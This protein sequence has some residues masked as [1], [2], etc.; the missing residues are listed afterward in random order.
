MNKPSKLSLMVKLLFDANILYRLVKKLIKD[1]PACVHVSKTELSI[2]ALDDEIWNWAKNNDFVIVTND[3][4]FNNLSQLYGFPPKIIILRT[5]NQSTDF[6]AELFQ[7]RI[8][9][10]ID[11]INDNELGILEIF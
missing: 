5:G 6:I 4:D 10:I 1:Y 3:D 8:E 11:F 9:T 2:P 7:N